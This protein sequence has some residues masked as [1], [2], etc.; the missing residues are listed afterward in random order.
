[1]DIT[2][3]LHKSH[4]ARTKSARKVKGIFSSCLLVVVAIVLMVPIFWL[5]ITS[6]KVNTEYLTYPIVLLPAAPQWSNFAAVFS[7]VYG[8]LKH[9]GMTLFLAVVFSTLTVFSSSLCGYA[10]AR[11]RDVKASAKLFGVIIAMIIIPAIVTVI[12]SYMIFAKLHLTGSYW[13]WVLWG[14]AG[15]PY[16][17]FLFRQFFLSFPKELEDSAEV[18]GCSPFGIFWRIFLPNAKAAI[19]TSFILNFMWVWGEW[20]I[21]QIYL[22]ADNTTLPV[23]INT[24]FKNPQGQFLTTL[25]VASIVIYTMPI[26]V[27]FFFTQKYILKGVVTSGLSGR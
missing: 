16:H 7:P 4:P 3:S 22:R 10:F 2:Q 19:A 8:F 17:I 5:V 27:I 25:T 24:I 13:P 14:L 1:M 6:L 26:V 9:A 18:D 21:P 23:L 15:S 20:L 12:P 11:F